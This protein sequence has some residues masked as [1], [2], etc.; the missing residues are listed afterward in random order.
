MSQKQPQEMPADAKRPAP[1][2]AP[3]KADCPACRRRAAMLDGDTD[4]SDWTRPDLEE[5]ICYR[6]DESLALRKQLEEAREK[7]APAALRRRIAELE[8]DL[9]KVND[10]LRQANEAAIFGALPTTNRTEENHG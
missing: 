1:P 7:R 3:P 9:A 10:R 2:P 4:F 8:A 5:E 6:I